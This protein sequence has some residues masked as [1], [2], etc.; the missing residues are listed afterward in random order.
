MTD[1]RLHE[2]KRDFWTATSAEHIA[3][4]NGFGEPQNLD[5]LTGAAA[6]LW[7]SD[8]EFDAFLASIDRHRRWPTST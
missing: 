1:D 5:L 6:D 3:A 8:E 4:E 2:K 7:S